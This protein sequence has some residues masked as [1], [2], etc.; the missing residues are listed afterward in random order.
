MAVPSW[1]A[2]MVKGVSVAAAVE[3]VEDAAVEVV[4]VE[5]VVGATEVVEVRGRRD[6]LTDGKTGA[7]E[8]TAQH[9]ASPAVGE[10]S[11]QRA[12]RGGSSR[13]SSQ[14]PGW[15]IPGVPSPQRRMMLELSLPPTQ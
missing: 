4:E 12:P 10:D 13:L 14:F 3:V 8:P 7:G 2:M 9:T 15:R 11:R 5:V 6:P 1:A